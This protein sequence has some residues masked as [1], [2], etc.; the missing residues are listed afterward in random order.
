MDVLF[1]PSLAEL[2]QLRSEYPLGRI[3]AGGTDLLVELRKSA[4]RPAVL[5]A[6]ERIAELKKIEVQMQQC[7]IGAAVTCSEAIESTLIQDRFPLLGQALLELASPPVRHAATLAGNICTASPAADSLPALY[8]L[9]AEVE[10]AS[11]EGFR[12]LPIAEFITGPGRTQL[13]GHEVMTGIRIPLQDK[14]FPQSGYLK[15]GK[16]K[17]MAIAIV[18]LAYHYSLSS[19]GVVDEIGLAWGSVAPTVVRVPEAENVLVGRRFSQDAFQQAVKLI[20]AAIEPID[21]LRA[22]ADYRRRVAVNLM[23]RIPAIQ[24]LNGGSQNAAPT[25]H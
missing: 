15:V 21:D 3:L 12:R 14:C 19:A 23:N 16:R 7:F 6:T 20:N 24:L 11:T 13:Q 2:C 8:L 22:S 4:N 17:A 9:N 25:D 18:S 5:I 10:L 1:P